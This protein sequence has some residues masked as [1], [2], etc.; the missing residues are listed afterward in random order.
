VR[1]L[2]CGSLLV[3]R[4]PGLRLV[5][6]F[7]VLLSTSLLIGCSINS[8][9][10]EP[11]AATTSPHGALK[12]PTP[13]IE[14]KISLEETLFKR[15]SVRDYASEGLRLEEVSQLLWAAQGITAE[16]GG[17]T[18]PSAGG[19]Y[20][21]TVYLVAGNVEDLA[22]GV[23]KYNPERH[24]LTMVKDGDFRE[25]MAAASL[26]QTWVK[27]G[28]INIIIA[29]VYEITTGKYGERG[30]RYVH[31]E[32]GHAAQNICLQATALN[33]GAVT[34]GAFEDD[35]I[36][37]TVGMAANENPLYVIPVGRVR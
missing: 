15:R 37:Q 3:W 11:V 26:D 10:P 1:C 28:A 5:S 16:W 18:A 2:I 29:A 6:L 21:L 20:P 23:Y 8:A 4:K 24:E 31:M 25:Q 13:K 34:V 30:F 12:L 22:G 36:R 19:L 32:A 33:L 27:E 17:R 9:T 35:Q 14:G 7:V